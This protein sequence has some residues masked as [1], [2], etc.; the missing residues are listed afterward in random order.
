MANVK[1]TPIGVID[2]NTDVRYVNRGNYT[3]A[4]NIRHRDV[5]TNNTDGTPYLI[6][7]TVESIAIPNITTQTK[8]YRINVATSG[9][10]S[11]TV[12][13]ENIVKII[14]NDLNTSFL[15]TENVNVTLPT[16]V[17]NTLSDLN[18]GSPGTFSN[19]TTGSF[20]VT[21]FV[22]PT[23]AGQTRNIGSI[24][25]GPSGTTPDTI[26]M[27]SAFGSG[28]AG[29]AAGERWRYN[30][31]GNTPIGGLVDGQ[32]YYIGST[33]FTNVFSLHN[34]RAEAIIF[35]NPTR[36]NLTG[37]L[38]GT[39]SFTRIMDIEGYFDITDTTGLDQS[40]QIYVE[41]SSGYSSPVIVSA[42]LIQDHIYQTETLKIVG[43]VNI[44]NDLF[45]ISTTEKT[46]YG[47]YS[48]TRPTLQVNY[49]EIGYVT[50]DDN[51]N[52]H[53]YTRLLRTKDLGL[54]PNYRVSGVGEKRSTGVSI[55]ITN[56]DA[57]PRA[58][59]LKSPYTQDSA[60]IQ[61]GGDYSLNTIELE[62]RLFQ[63]S[64][65]SNINLV[66]VKENS[67]ILTCGIKRYTGYF[68][69][70]GRTPSE[71]LLPSGPIA[72]YNKPDV[73]HVDI[74]GDDYNITSDKS[75]KL[76]ID[77]I[78]IGIYKYFVLVVIEN[79]GDSFA[80]NKVREYSLD[81]SQNF[82]D[83][84]H[85]GFGDVPET[86]L[87]EDVV[88]LY[89]KYTK[90]QNLKL[91]S[92]R[93]VMSNLTE[94]VDR[95][96]STWATTITHALRER[97]LTSVGLMGNT[98]S[99]GRP[100][101]KYAEYQDPNN[102]YNFTGYM[103]NDTYR[104]GV[105]V[106]WKKSGKWST[107][108]WVDDIRF[109]TL[110]F[111][112]LNDPSYNRRTAN[113]L[114]TNLTE[115]AT[116]A[117]TDADFTLFTKSYY[118]EFNNINLAYTFA[119]GSI[120]KNE[121][122]ALRFVR[123]ERIPE[124]LLTGMFHPGFATT[125]PKIVPDN[126]IYTASQ[127]SIYHSTH[128][129]DDGDRVLYMFSPDI[130]YGQYQYQYSASDTLKLMGSVNIGST[131]QGVDFTEG[132]C[133]GTGTDSAYAD[134]T[135]FF[136]NQT[137]SKAAYEDWTISASAELSS[138][139]YVALSTFQVSKHY[140]VT[141][142]LRD[143]THAFLL[144]ST[145][146]KQVGTT[147]N[148]H[149]NDN[150]LYYGQVFRNLGA[151]LK[152]PV[153]KR[154]TLYYGTGQFLKV[155][156]FSAD[157]VGTISVFGGDVYNQKT[158]IKFQIA[159]TK[160]S[161]ATQSFGFYSQN[162][163]NTQ[164]C[165][166]EEHTLSDS[167]PGYKFPQYTEVG[168]VGSASRTHPVGSWGNGLLYWVE[169]WD[170][171]YRQSSYNAGYNATVDRVG[172]IGFDQ[173]STYD[174]KKPSTMI[175][176]QIKVIGEAIDAYRLF[177]PLDF[178]D[179]DI[180]N[181]EIAHHEV[182]NNAVY[183]WQ[184]NSFQRQY[185]AETT[186]LNP[187]QGASIVLGTGTFAG[188]PGAELSSIGCDNK[189]AIIKGIT[190][191]GKDVVY[192]YNE[193]LRKIVRFGQDGVKVISD[194]TISS[195]LTRDMKYLVDQNNPLLNLGVHGGWNNRYSEAIFTFKG[196]NPNIQKWVTSTS[197][198]VGNYV[199]PVS[200]YTHASGMSFVYR[201]IL[202]HTSG[203]STQPETGASWTTYW[204]KV[205]P[206]TDSNTHTLFTWV[207]DE[208]KNGFITKMSVYPSLFMS[209]RIGIY[210]VSPLERNKLY[211]HDV[212][213]YGSFYG[214]TFDGNIE[215][216][217]NF[218]PNIAKNFEAVQILSDVAPNRTDFYTKNHTSFNTSSEFDLRENLYF[219]F[220]RNDSTGT[221]VATNDTSR[222]WGTYLKTKFT[223][224]GGVA[225]KLFNLIVKFRLMPRLYN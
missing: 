23:D 197:Y 71:Y 45:L 159:D 89:S 194:Q 132:H 58:I 88:K 67:G 198:V 8:T 202:N 53:T 50:Y 70:E 217:M 131:N 52:V 49:T 34:T 25:I 222:L 109:D 209:N 190:P 3:D 163:T 164:L 29:F 64:S 161:V 36:I 22:I 138:N 11:G 82:L 81:E 61:N 80:V 96:L 200:T 115:G 5:D 21:K 196:I 149:G 38:V 100:A 152:Y 173:Q 127:L 170:S 111:N 94:E 192:W 188:P 19:V 20:V 102:I 146:F 10:Y 150:R 68:L 214:T 54:S 113:T 103:M 166:V 133:I 210:S 76:Q 177:M 120:L 216:V 223:F 169:T 187:Q 108:Y 48:A 118:V 84:E 213:N 189:W 57:A 124:V 225:Q 147:S 160:L 206:G 107:V 218:E 90:V 73:N 126:F 32:F 6:K 42:Q 151:N 154:Q 162:I 110:A 182:V 104:F 129:S 18:A 220:I 141:K 185:F 125:S 204:A 99:A 136:D 47:A 92:N 105:Q 117:A 43:E 178:L 211:L 56:S 121:I 157:V 112:I 83:I 181:G 123:A 95:D 153:D 66:E 72:I 37:T 55:Y 86:V 27:A 74:H 179:L 98:F 30:A 175:W 128:V 171:V 135:G 180:T 2:Q 143:V 137:S 40:Y 41:A 167:G 219:G 205:T 39:Q 199:L 63:T 208:L 7:G 13:G 158:H 193:K 201:C 14:S 15:V 176:S 91:F 75:V 212:G 122:E 28:Y 195:S 165:N 16:L 77:N 119:D 78:P 145:S 62:T 17:T 224:Q 114:N 101:Y 9:N 139:D 184:Q 4:L 186:L 46:P 60:L 69:T 148:I 207:W 130:Y 79:Q 35:N 191:S 65:T 172:N 12:T 116:G 24:D 134:F 1:V 59:Y 97:K 44:E 203:A 156:E 221:G 174:G 51:S 144:P 215:M 142:S 26:T 106:K 168:Q 183:T 140:L 33:G 93:L 87:L 31:N 85:T 155:D